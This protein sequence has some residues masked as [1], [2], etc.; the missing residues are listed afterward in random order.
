LPFTQWALV[1][2]D[3]LSVLA[4]PATVLATSSFIETTCTCSDLMK[5]S[6][7]IRRPR[8]DPL[9]VKQSAEAGCIVN[10]RSNFGPTHHMRQRNANFDWLRLFLAGSVAYFHAGAFS[11]VANGQNVPFSVIPF[12]MVPT[13]LALSG[14][15][16]FDSFASS[17]SYGHFVKKRALRILPGL[18]VALV[19]SGLV[20]GFWEGVVGS[21]Q[22]YIGGG[23]LI[24]PAGG[25][26]SLWSLLW[27]EIA[28]ATMAILIAVKAYD[29]R[30]VIWIC[31]GIGCYIAAVNNQHEPYWRITNLLP[32]LFTGNLVYLYRQHI[33][34]LSWL[35]LVVVTIA[36]TT[37]NHVLHLQ[38]QTWYMVPIG[39]FLAL[40]LCLNAPAL[41]KL[42]FDISYGLYVLH[43]PVFYL[44]VKV[45][46]DSFAS[47]FGI[48]APA[49][50]A[51]ALLSWYLIEK[52]ALRL[53]SRSR[54]IDRFQKD[55]P[56]TAPSDPGRVSGLQLA[57]R[58]AVRRDEAPS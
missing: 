6:D 33:A 36:V 41:P 5:A 8:L 58:D 16:M 30:W 25:N 32:A 39:S 15:L 54:A 19:V 46:P 9:D 7:S 49:L 29:R 26:G 51:L 57:Q 17:R 52:P 18:A 11:Q 50:I 21:L 44:A 14:Y 42:P 31:W 45:V 38:P 3:L 27:E 34:K 10:M 12:P 28:Y 56:A 48:G 53:K 55:A 43:D 37:T 23:V 2:V 24:T 1:A 22:F 13:F 4:V 20:W 35:M 40:S 47:M